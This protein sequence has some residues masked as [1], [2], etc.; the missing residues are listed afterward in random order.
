MNQ[1]QT[2]PIT[3]LQAA[4]N[5]QVANW[6]VLYTKLHRYHWY[7]KGPHFFTLHEK[8][9]ELYN[10]AANI[11][12]EAAERLLTIGG[13]PIATMGEYLQ[14]TTLA[15]TNHEKTAN[16]MVASLIADYKQLREELYALASLAED[17]QAPAT[18]DFAVGLIAS[19]DQHIWMFHAYLGE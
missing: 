8:F 7:V 3:K 18:N 1:V 5:T 6:S 11:V 15:E 14:A 10:E 13:E 19:I 9:E 2:A 12:D 17:E 4:L 16:E